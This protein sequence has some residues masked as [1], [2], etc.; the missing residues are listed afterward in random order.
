MK[1]KNIQQNIF[2]E[3]GVASEKQVNAEKR[4]KERIRQK[5]LTAFQE[6]SDKC[7]LDETTASGHC[8]YMDFCDCCNDNTYGRPCAR[9]F[10][11]YIQKNNIQVDFT[12]L[13]IE[14]YF[15]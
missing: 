5:W 8:G 7:A 10:I 2:G 1:N 13:N 9:A 11:K 15:D 4:E 12:D 6:Y 3:L 14:K